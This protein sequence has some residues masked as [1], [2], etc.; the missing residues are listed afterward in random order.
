M[1]LGT[2]AF[3]LGW[4]LILWQLTGQYFHNLTDKAM[5]DAEDDTVQ[6]ALQIASSIQRGMS[7]LHGIPPTLAQDITLRK[8]LQTALPAPQ[9][10]EEKRRAWSREPALVALNQR[11]I[12]ARKNFDMVSVIWVM[13][14]AGDA[15]AASNADTEESFIGTNYLDREYF[16]EARETTRGNQFAIGR[17]TNIPGL[18][19]S[20]SVQA[21][22]QF[23]GVV[24]IK[25]DIPFFSSWIEQKETFIT[26]KHGVIVLARNKN[27]EMRS[28]PDASVHTLSEK[29]R[30]TRYKLKEL[31]TWAIT[32]WDAHRFPDLKRVQGWSLP[33]LLRT[34]P[35]PEEELSINVIT[36]IPSFG[37]MRQERLQWF[38]LL[39]L[40]GV[41]LIITV[42]GKISLLR[43]HRENESRL[44]EI[45]A[46]LAEGLFVIDQEK[47]I[48]FINP[49]ALTML[50]WQEETL[51]GHPLHA[52][53]CPTDDPSHPHPTCPLC[54]LLE[55]NRVVT[56]QNNWLRRRD[57]SSMPVSLIAS[58]ITR[59][60]THAGTVVAFRDITN[61]LN[62]EELLRSKERAEQSARIKED[63]LA[64]MSHEIR[65]PMNVV[66]GMSEV[67]LASNP[68]PEQTRLLQT[69]HN[70]GKTLLG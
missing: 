69:M 35:I 41:L 26:D 34:T 18:Y 16:Q 47:R 45:T 67:L 64:A 1:L 3:V 5:A 24:A 20:S 37:T 23:L 57:G 17:R 2:L 14:A 58:P 59:H 6:S 53:C 43:Q 33:V 48:T 36:P 49:A 10:R 4:S 54:A 68:D 27:M 46:T 31:S 25:I 62:E 42:T 55:Q 65:T 9:T 29:E 8:A 56:A 40:I 44:R 39:E 70:S 28:I 60:Q 52:A 61:Q 30:E 21:D 66:L 19:F 63:F 22:G 7:V 51:L 13:N 15:M 50:G 12:A 11:L 32:P 38:F